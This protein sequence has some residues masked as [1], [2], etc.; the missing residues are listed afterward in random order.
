MNRIGIFFI[1]SNGE[2]I[3]NHIPYKKGRFLNGLYDSNSDHW[4]LFDSLIFKF[5]TDDYIKRTIMTLEN[6]I[7]SHVI[8]LVVSPLKAYENNIG[9]RGEADLIDLER[10]KMFRNHLEDEFKRR[11]FVLN[12][13]DDASDIYR[14][15][16]DI[17]REGEI[18]DDI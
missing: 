14:Y 6:M 7:D 18:A 15:C 2:I 9:L 10:L 4:E 12:F 1:C 5:D 13:E 3:A 16:V 8:A 11:S 17:F